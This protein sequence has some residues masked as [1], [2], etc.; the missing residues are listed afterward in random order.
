[1]GNKTRYIISIIFLVAIIVLA[2]LLHPIASTLLILLL[3]YT[4]NVA[5]DYVFYYWSKKVKPNGF[6]SFLSS[7]VNGVVTNIEYGVSLMSHIQ[8]CDC[9]TKEIILDLKKHQSNKRYNHI[10]IFLNKF[11]K[12]IVTN[13]GSKVKSIR[14]YDPNTEKYCMVKDGLVPKKNGRYLTNPF[15]RVDYENGAV[16]VFTLDKYVS[17]IVLNESH[18][19]YG[20]DMFICR[21][22]Q[23]DVYIPTEYSFYPHIGQVVDNYDILSFMPCEQTEINKESVFAD[24]DTLIKASGVTK[25]GLLLSNL[26]K[27][28]GVFKNSSLPYLVSLYVGCLIGCPV[29]IIFV[30]LALFSFHRFYKNYL[31]VRMNEVGLFTPSKFYNHVEKTRNILIKI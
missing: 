3:L 7:P 25:Q 4:N 21:G 30:F 15:V 23:C 24:A 19:R 1:M 28:L 12:H 20:I 27:T 11:N 13:I 5:D 9:L 17:E 2:P 16:C 26:P 14:Q 8:K 6:H 18:S 10:T 22:S 31:Y 29:V